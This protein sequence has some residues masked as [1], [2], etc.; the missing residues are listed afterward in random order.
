MNCLLMRELR[1]SLIIR[2]WDTYTLFPQYT[3]M[4]QKCKTSVREVS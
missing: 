1:L 4:L 3:R 2:L